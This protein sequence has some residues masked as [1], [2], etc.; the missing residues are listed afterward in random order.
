MQTYFTDSALVQLP[1]G[2][3]MGGAYVAIAIHA[4]SFRHA[5]DLAR[6]SCRMDD[7]ELIDI[8]PLKLADAVLLRDLSAYALAIVRRVSETNL[9]AYGDFYA[10]PLDDGDE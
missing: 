8:G 9:I 6:Q 4:E 7:Y 1:P 5:V 2:S 10:F 3:G